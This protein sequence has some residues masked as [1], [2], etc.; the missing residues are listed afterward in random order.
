MPKKITAN[1]RE[2]LVA[3]LRDRYQRATRREKALILNEFVAVSG[4]H[5]KH[6]IRVLSGAEEH[7]EPRV[8]SSR[9]R[10]YDEA[11]R[12]A[13]T[14]LWEASDRVCGKR[15]KPLLPTLVPALERH[16]HLKLDSAI[17]ERVLAASAATIDRLLGVARAST[18]AGIRK[19]AKPAVRQQIAVRTFADWKDPL[20]G[21]MEIDLVAHCGDTVAGSFVHT[22]VL[23]DVATG[24]TECVPLVVRESTLVVD[25]IER[26]RPAL[27]FQLLGLDSD[28]G[29]EFVNELLVKYCAERGIELTRSRP[30]RKN[31]QAWVEQK[32]GAV[33]R[34][35]VGYHRLEGI[36][37]AEALSRLYSASRL[38]VN[39]FQPS[40]KLASKTRIG[41]RVRKHYHPPQTPSA[42]LLAAS[43]ISGHVKERLSEVALKLDPLRLLDQI[44]TMQQH[45]VAV[46]A[47]EKLHLPPRRDDQ[48]ASFLA[49]L[50][51]AWRAGEVR[52]THCPKQ[53]PERHW[54][55]RTDPFETVWPLVAEW[56]DAEPEQTALQL[57]ERLHAVEPQKYDEK[58]LR[59]L[60][61]RVKEWRAAAARRLIFGA[62]TM[63]G[64]SG[65]ANAERS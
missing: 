23:T 65:E 54:R 6:A 40:F 13:L 45:V 52:P 33:V 57:L 2:E 28:N 63:L 32:N 31:D 3:A 37:G 48:L 14:T 5:R 15:L 35:L 42:R 44:R 61:R 56:L 16:G 49:S 41:A 20:P 38:F 53:R 8:R 46:A 55:T 26:L 29:S 10:L 24:W 50:S 21:N 17:R 25:A 58:L 4:Y 27:P 22:L 43:S 19:G 39:F 11:V 12:Q 47:G 59:T 51:T 1:A 7:S 30:Y 18:R 9:P 36:A 62:P 60:Q 64:V 34:R